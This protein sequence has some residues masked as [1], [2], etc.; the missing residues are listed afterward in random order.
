[1]GEL[2]AVM[3]GVGLVPLRRVDYLP[4]ESI[5]VKINKDLLRWFEYVDKWQMKG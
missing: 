2:L 5:D 1:M 4:L 3:E